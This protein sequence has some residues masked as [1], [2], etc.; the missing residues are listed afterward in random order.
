M[1]IYNFFKKASIE[2]IRNKHQKT[3]ILR[4]AG[5]LAGILIL[6][7]VFSLLPQ[8]VRAVTVTATIPVG[9]TLIGVAVSPNGVYVYV[10]NYLDNSVSV[11]S[12]A[13]NTVTATVAVGVYPIG[14]E[15]DF[16]IR[17]TGTLSNL[18]MVWYTFA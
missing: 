7:C 15:E 4:V 9:S 17:P 16:A 11:V 1:K 14:A 12:T 18:S 3:K 2:Q 8:S 13:S 6:F 5:I 10:T